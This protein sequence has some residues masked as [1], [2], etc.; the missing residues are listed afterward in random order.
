LFDIQDTLGAVNRSRTFLA[1]AQ[2]CRTLR[3]IVFDYRARRMDD[4]PIFV[5]VGD[6]YRC[7][8]YPNAT[9]ISM[10][11]TI[12][13]LRLGDTNKIHTKE[14]FN[15]ERGTRWRDGIRIRVCG[16]GKSRKNRPYFRPAEVIEAYGSAEP[17]DAAVSIE[18]VKEEKVE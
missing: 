16:R 5:R 15:F 2:T 9:I 14:V 12:A 4:P 10:R 6:I 7:K 8:G 13:K 18:A 3:R 11:R 1:L 17:V